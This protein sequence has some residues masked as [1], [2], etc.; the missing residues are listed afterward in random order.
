MKALSETSVKQGLTDSRRFSLPAVGG[1]G[2]A[3]T[4]GFLPASESPAGFRLAARSPSILE[5]FTNSCTVLHK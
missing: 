2:V 1:N 5:S 3:D 4:A